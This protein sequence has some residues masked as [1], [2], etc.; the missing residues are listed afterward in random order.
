[1]QGNPDVSFGNQGFIDP[2]VFKPSLVLPDGK[3]VG[4]SVHGLIRYLPEGSPDPGFL[5][6]GAVSVSWF[7]NMVQVH[8]ARQSDSKVVVAGTAPLASSQLVLLRFNPDGSLDA[9]FNGGGMLVAPPRSEPQRLVR[10]PRDS[11]GRQDCH[12]RQQ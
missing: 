6:D 4:Q 3:I 9:A 8:W 10:R 1:V 5:T 12:C 7:A 2:T 11:A